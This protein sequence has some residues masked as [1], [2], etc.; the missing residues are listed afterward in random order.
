MVDDEFPEAQF[1]FSHVHH[2]R[3]FC[4]KSHSSHTKFLQHTRRRILEYQ[5]LMYFYSFT[6]ALIYFLSAR[7]GS[8]TV[9]PSFVRSSAACKRSSSRNR[10]KLKELPK[11]L[12]R[13]PRM[14]SLLPLPWLLRLALLLLP[15]PLHPLTQRQ[16]GRQQH[17]P[18]LAR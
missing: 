10:K 16:R 11:V 5:L 2:I 14:I 18:S 7:F 6:Q 15:P 17:G 1:S 9:G 13:T 8:R 4:P 3:G 12:Q